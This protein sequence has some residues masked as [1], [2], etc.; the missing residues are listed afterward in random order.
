MHSRWLDVGLAATLTIAGEIEVL[1]ADADGSRLVTALILPVATVSL[2]SR[3]RRPLLPVAAITVALLAQAALGGALFGHMAAPVVA[4]VIAL[5]T[6][7]RHIASANALAAAAGM[8]LVIVTTRNVFDPAVQRLADAVLT[9][10][11]VPLPLIVGRWVR[12]QVALQDELDLK[13]EELDRERRRNARQAAEDERV[14]IAS[15]LQEAV[16]GGLGMIIEEARELPGRL[17]AGERL[18][19]RAS[20]AS[21]ADAARDALGDVRRVLGILRREGEAPPLTPPAGASVRVSAAVAAVTRA[22]HAPPAD[23]GSAPRARGHGRRWASPLRGGAPRSVDQAL[24]A[25]LLLGAEIELALQVPGDLRLLA[26]L[27]A[28]L[29]LAPLLWRRRLPVFVIAAVLAAVAVQSTLLGLASFPGFDIAAVVCASYALGAYADRRPAIAGLLLGATGAAAHALVFYPS[30]VVPALLG[31]VG[32]PWIVGRIV[33]GQRRLTSEA[34]EKAR[35]DEHAREQEARAATT[36]ERMRM[37]RELHD[38]V[39]HSISVIAIQAAG[40]EPLV[41][42]DRERAAQCAVLIEQTAREALAELGRLLHP[43]RPDAA[44]QPSL[45]RVAALA[46]RARDAGVHVKVHVEGAPVALPAGIDLAAYR[47]VQEALTNTSKHAG[48]ARADVTVRYERRAV[49][50]EIGDD[51]RGPDG[52]PIDVGGHGI[53]GMRERVALYGGTLD[54][55]GRPGGGFRVH[56]RLPIGRP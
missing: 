19:A 44:P 36:A 38:A 4:L 35:R 17:A 43:L 37:A 11:Y 10:I 1:L 47:I 29:V 42:R 23:A 50:I 28:G 18:S 32:L 20:F 41:E 40:A 15:D 56:A 48:N 21:I 7:G 39:A 8:I 13:I 51:G 6:A 52:Q 22:D 54:V 25:V 27:T 14:R 24:V 34:T 30:G 33:R 2:V 9:G 55:G 5:Y 16:A 46:E 3:R 12:G 26:A 49:E 53:V 45:A 31:G